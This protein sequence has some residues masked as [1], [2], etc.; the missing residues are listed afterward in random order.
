MFLN[1]VEEILDVIEPSE[2]AKIHKPLFTQL[3][4]CVSSQHFQVAERALYYWNNEYIISLITDNVESILPIMFPSLYQNSKAHWNRTIHG[5]V[6]NAIKIFM[7]ISPQ[8]FDECTNRYRQDKS[9]ERQKQQQREDA[10]RQIEETAASKS[11][12]RTLPPIRPILNIPG[13]SSSTKDAIGGTVM[14]SPT[15][16]LPQPPPLIDD[17]EEANDEL[18]TELKKLRVEEGF[19]QTGT[20]GGSSPHVRRKSV[21]P[22]MDQSVLDELAMHKPLEMEGPA[23]G[24]SPSTR[25]PASG[26]LSKLKNARK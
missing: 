2:F 10:W 16:S 11:P 15:S 13:P 7:E 9:L 18:F 6:Y 14:A 8:L 21:I 1:E 20:T 22:S 25:Q 19:E 17:G 3:A 23:V 4:R 26:D 12:T 24:Q 5:L